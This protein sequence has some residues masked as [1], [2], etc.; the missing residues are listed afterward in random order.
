MWDTPFTE[1]MLNLPNGIVINCPTYESCQE[2]AEVLRQ[3][4]V[5]YGGPGDRVD[6][7]VDARH[8]G[9]HKENFCWYVKQ[10]RLWRGPRASTN[11]SPWSG[12]TKSTFYGG[13]DSIEVAS[14]EDIGILLGG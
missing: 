9:G 2:C 12:F 8:W 11:K 5:C 1:D 14:N 4:D 10:K 3:N 6:E 7:T 13:S